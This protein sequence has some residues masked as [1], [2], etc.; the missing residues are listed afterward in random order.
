MIDGLPFDP[1]HPPA[2]PPCGCVDPMLWRV[3]Y[4]LYVAHHPRP[5]GFCECR[6]FWP[7]E[8]ADLAADALSAAYDRSI[9]RVRTR[10]MNLGRF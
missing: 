7:C 3:A 10:A 8:R 4:A 5:D 2:E 9:P 6:A 1:Y